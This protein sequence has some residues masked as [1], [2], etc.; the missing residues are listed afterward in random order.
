[1][2]IAISHIQMLNLSFF[3]LLNISLIAALAIINTIWIYI[4]VISMRIHRNSPNIT[5]SQKSTSSLSSSSSSLSSCHHH[6]HHYL[7]VIFFPINFHVFSGERRRAT[8][9]HG[10]CVAGVRRG[11]AGARGA[12]ILNGSR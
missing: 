6:C 1:M 9:A 2:E 3:S 8:E 12:R 10:S 11:A 4:F 5:T 7:L